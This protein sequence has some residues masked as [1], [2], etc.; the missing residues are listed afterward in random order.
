VLGSRRNGGNDGE[1]EKACKLGDDTSQVPTESIARLIPRL[2]RA[3]ARAGRGLD[4]CEHHGAP[5]LQE[6]P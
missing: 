6:K 5:C 2:A 3:C 4:G 1:D